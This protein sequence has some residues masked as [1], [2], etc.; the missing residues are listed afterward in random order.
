MRDVLHL[1]DIEVAKIPQL[2]H[3]D[4]AVVDMFLH[5]L[6]MHCELMLKTGL[7]G[8]FDDCAALTVEFW[9]R[10]STDA[11]MIYQNGQLSR[12]VAEWDAQVYQAMLTIFLPD[13]LGPGD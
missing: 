8:R 9:R 4:L 11:P 6:R 2:E 13:I 3:M 1:N 10:W 5:Q 7:Q 12:I